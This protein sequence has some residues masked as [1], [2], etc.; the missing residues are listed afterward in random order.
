ML[1]LFSHFVN[2][3]TQQDFVLFKVILK[4]DDLCMS[5]AV[6][7]GCQSI[8]FTPNN[9]FNAVQTSASLLPGDVRSIYIFLWV[10]GSI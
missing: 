6:E 8:L 2:L 4:L 5:A 9:S 10:V 3:F 7:K 1:G